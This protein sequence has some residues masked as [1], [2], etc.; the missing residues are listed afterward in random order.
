MSFSGAHCLWVWVVIGCIHLPFM[1]GSHHVHGHSSFVCG[2]LLS[3]MGE[4]VAAV[5]GCRLLWALGH[6][7]WLSLWVLGVHGC[8]VIVCRSWAV[9]CGQWGSCAVYVVCGWW[10]VVCG[11]VVRG[12]GCGLLARWCHVMCSWLVKSD[13]TSEGRVLTIVDNLNNN[14]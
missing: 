10:M 6:R 8:S 13:G 4:V 2:G 7:L 12:L 5:P 1:G 9:V 3:S 11:Q 14:K